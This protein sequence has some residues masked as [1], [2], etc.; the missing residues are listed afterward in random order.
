M[1]KNKSECSLGVAN[2]FATVES[3]FL[4]HEQIFSMKIGVANYLH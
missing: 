2:L 1:E 3:K 4:F